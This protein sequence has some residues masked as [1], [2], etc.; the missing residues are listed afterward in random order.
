M[1]LSSTCLEVPTTSWSELPWC[2]KNEKKGVVSSHHPSY[3]VCWWVAVDSS[4]PYLPYQLI[5]TMLTPATE[6][7]LNNTDNS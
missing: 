7:M 1:N 4:N 2:S 3:V 6:Y 5:N